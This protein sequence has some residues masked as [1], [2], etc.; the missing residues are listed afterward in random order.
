MVLHRQVFYKISTTGI[1]SRHLISKIN[2]TAEHYRP[3]TICQH[4]NADINVSGVNTTN[5]NTVFENKLPIVFTAKRIA[6]NQ[7]MPFR[8]RSGKFVLRYSPF[9]NSVT[10]RKTFTAM[11]RPSNTTISSTLF[12]RPAHTIAYGIT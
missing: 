5:S 6:K 2:P 1:E 9:I 10:I 3:L 11:E 8:N 7:M 12:M 4:K